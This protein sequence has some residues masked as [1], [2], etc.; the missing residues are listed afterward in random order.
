[1]ARA[2]ARRAPGVADVLAAIWRNSL[3]QRVRGGAVA[4]VGLAFGLA[5]AS[6]N[7]ADPSLNASTANPASNLVGRLGAAAL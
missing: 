3:F 2:A 1:M 7:A 5:L 4:I 6:Y